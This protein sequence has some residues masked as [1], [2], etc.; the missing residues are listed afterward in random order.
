MAS[1]LSVSMLVSTL[2]PPA[3]SKPPYSVTCKA[4]NENLRNFLQYSEKAPVLVYSKVTQ[5]CV[6]VDEKPDKAELGL[7]LT[8]LTSPLP[9]VGDKKPPWS[10][11]MVPTPLLP[12]P[13]LSFTVSQVSVVIQ[14]LLGASNLIDEK[15]SRERCSN[16]SCLVFQVRPR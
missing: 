8:S 3:V 7:G 9:L 12:L 2:A 5:C 15:P 11:P 10:P 16:H 6:Q 14:H 4:V 13:T 1:T